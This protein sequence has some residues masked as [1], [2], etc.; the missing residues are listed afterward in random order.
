MTRPPPG[1]RRLALPGRR[2]VLVHRRSLLV[3]CCLAV[4][5][6]AVAAATLAT[7]T[8]TIAPGRVLEILGGGQSG[9]DA[10]LVGEQRAPRVVAAALVGAALAGSGGIF[11]SLSRNP[12]GSPDLIGFTTGAASGGLVTILL[13]GTTGGAAVMLG[14]F[15]GGLATAG[16]AVLVNHRSASVGDRLIVGGIALAAM[17][18]SVNDYLISRADIQA[19]EVAKAWQYGSL[20]V[21]TWPP[22]QVLGA[23]VALLAPA[24]AGCA[25]LLRFMELGD[26]ASS[27]IGVPLSRARTA[28]LVVGVALAAIAVAVAG[29]IGFIALVAPQVT[30]RVAGAPGIVLWPTML[31]GS[32]LLLVG[33]LLAQRLLSPFQIP[34]GLVT[35]ALGGTYLTWLLLRPQRY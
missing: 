7:G 10:F 24:A 32:L 11:Q 17:L 6:L 35:A 12:L 33:D 9:T 2:A 23:V 13:L 29:P 1:Y 26:D 27:G 3:S 4:L 18:A 15:V 34:V 20:N 30:R 5:C 28:A 31:M 19:A 21:I 22:V 14:T 8:Y 16:A 25:H